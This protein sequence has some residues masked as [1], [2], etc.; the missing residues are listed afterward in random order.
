MTDNPF[1]GHITSEEVSAIV[2]APGNS[3]DNFVE[4]CELMKECQDE[5][6]DL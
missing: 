3:I 4:W 1:E 2:R 5:L 6:D